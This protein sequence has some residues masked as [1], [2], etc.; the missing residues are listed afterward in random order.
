[1]ESETIDINNSLKIWVI[2]DEWDIDY[3]ENIVNRL[4]DGQRQTTFLAAMLTPEFLDSGWTN[5]E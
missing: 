5:L 3:N 2:F 4:S 1:M